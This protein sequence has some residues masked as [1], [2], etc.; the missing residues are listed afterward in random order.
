MKPGPTKP[1]QAEKGKRRQTNPQPLQVAQIADALLRMKTAAQIAGLSE[2]TLYRRAASDP[3][4]PK[5]IKMGARAT[6]IRAGDL[7]AWLAAQAGA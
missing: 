4:F 2:A 7:T 5:L 1:A 3:T 6:R